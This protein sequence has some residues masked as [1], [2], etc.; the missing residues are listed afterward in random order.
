MV[1]EPMKAQRMSRLEVWEMSFL[2][3]K[4]TELYYEVHGR[5]QPIVFLSETAC[6]GE[7]WKIHQVE[8]FSRDHR[9][10]IARLPRTGRSGKPSIDY[11]TKMFCDDAAALMDHL[12]AEKA[13]VIGHSMGGR[14]AQLLALEHPDKVDKLVLASRELLSRPP[15]TSPQDLQEMIEWGYENMCGITPS[16]LAS[17]TSSQNSIPIV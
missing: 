3:L 5:G 2:Q 15:R 12:G 7:V 16:L 1:Y 13:I 9:V 8:E 11:S 10:I 14:I 4:D 6:D 17:P